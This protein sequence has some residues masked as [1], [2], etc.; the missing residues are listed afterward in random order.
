MRARRLC[1]WNV[2]SQVEHVRESPVLREVPPVRVYG[3][4][5]DVADGIL[6][7]RTR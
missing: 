1:E 2:E 3:L 4:V 7:R 6:R 5:Y